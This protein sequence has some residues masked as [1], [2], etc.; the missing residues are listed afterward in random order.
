M[1]RPTRARHL[2]LVAPCAFALLAGC[3]CQDD[4]PSASSSETPAGESAPDASSA[5]DQADAPAPPVAPSPGT[6]I[7][8]ADRSRRV[9][10]EDEVVGRGDVA[11]RGDLVTYHYVMSVAG[12]AVVE[13]THAFTAPLQARLGKDSIL[14]PLADGLVGMRAGGRRKLSVPAHL[15]FGARGVEGKV[16]PNSDLEIVVELLTV[17]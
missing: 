6:P 13:D 3:R 17:E 16:P 10:A 5:S 9:I 8:P 11:A 12:G 15:A 4:G 1:P 14:H 2:W 7:D